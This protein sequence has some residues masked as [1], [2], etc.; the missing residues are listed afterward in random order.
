MLI[1]LMLL[2]KL[3]STLSSKSGWENYRCENFLKGRS[4]LHWSCLFVYTGSLFYVTAV[5]WH[6]LLVCC[7]IGLSSRWSMHAHAR[8]E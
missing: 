1:L 7:I 5:S 8:M 6:F 2:M 3:C 4:I